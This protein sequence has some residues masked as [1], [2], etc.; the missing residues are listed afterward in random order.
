MSKKRKSLEEGTPPKKPRGKS[1]EQ[2]DFDENHVYSTIQLR[3]HSALQKHDDLIN[4]SLRGL[5]RSCAHNV[6]RV[7]FEAYLL[8]NMHVL[9]L[10]QEKKPLPPLDQSFFK[11]CCVLVSKTIR[12]GGDEE[13]RKTMEEISFVASIQL[14]CA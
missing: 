14:G 4:H 3:L 5:L 1:K 13:L 8:A 10:I 2:K 9:R 7:A 12:G 11:S 6:S